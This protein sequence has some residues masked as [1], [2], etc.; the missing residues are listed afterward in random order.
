VNN[1]LKRFGS[2]WA[3]FFDAERVPALGYPDSAF[4]DPASCSSIGKGQASFEGERDHYES[5]HHLTLAW[6]PPPTA[7]PAPSGR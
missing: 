3:L 5:R 2:G 7:R 1:V 6:L 4:P